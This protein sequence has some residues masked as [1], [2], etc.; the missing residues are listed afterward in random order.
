MDNFSLTD[1]AFC[2]EK[3]PKELQNKEDVLKA[4]GQNGITLEFASEKF[5]ND[6]DVVLNSVKQ[7]GLA[8]KFASKEL[9]N[10]REIVLE[11]IK[12]NSSAMSFVSK[13]LQKDWTVS[14]EFKK[15]CRI[16]LI[17]PTKELQNDKD[18]V[19][20]AMK[21][22]EDAF[23]FASKEIQNN[24]EVVLEA[25]KQDTLNMIYVSK[26]LKN[27]KEIVLE[28][29]KKDG[30]I[31]QFVSK[32]L[33]ND[34]DV[35]LV[36]VNQN[37][38]ALEFASKELQNDK[39]ILLESGMNLQYASKE[40]Q[41]DKEI[42]LKSVKQNGNF[43]QFASKELQNDKEIVLEAMK[44]CG[45]SLKFASKEL[46]ND[47]DIVLEALKKFGNVLEFASKELLKDRDIIIQ[48][49][50]TIFKIEPNLDINSFKSALIKILLEDKT[51]F[52]KNIQ[53]RLVDYIFLE[54]I[55]LYLM[56]FK[57]KSFKISSEL[58]HLIAMKLKENELQENH[59]IEIF[60]KGIELGEN[61]SFYKECFFELGKIFSIGNC[62]NFNLSEEYLNQSISM[63]F[64]VK[65]STSL[66]NK[67][68]KYTKNLDQEEKSILEN[69]SS[70]NSYEIVRYFTKSSDASIYLVK[71]KRDGKE[72]IQKRFLVDSEK[73]TFNTSLKEV[74]MLIKLKH[75]LIC[76]F[77]DFYIEEQEHQEEID[78]YFSIIMP[79]Y[80]QDL[81]N[82]VQKVELEEEMITELILN[83]SYGIHF[84]HSQNI[85]HRD[86]KPEN[87]FLT[88]DFKIK[89]GDFGL[90][91]QTSMQTMRKTQ[92][93]TKS[94]FNV[95]LMFQRLC[96]SRD[97]G[98]KTI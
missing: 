23:Q 42:V 37:G 24:R 25:L 40:L 62:K 60:K 39:E 45:L 96:C 64:K 89:I 1:L 34:K 22:N 66:L 26:E 20:E 75:E 28:C 65:E 46:Q 85:I 2:L 82:Y 59:C 27:D 6:K 74:L 94:N 93:G 4:V 88:D 13:I 31:L 41:N 49:L 86:L 58:L 33:Q 51:K 3:T 11:A 12:Q 71:R 68:Q 76:G 18:F 17:F 69:C 32:E 78:Y 79:M 90:S 50:Q 81:R 43:L 95:S 98:I 35:V 70:A 56:I 55:E 15:K 44:Q 47:K 57:F 48:C 61:F 21:K 97:Y 72:F 9:Q 80:A 10:N 14:S 8:L 38:K 19:L 16:D 63:N 29:V 53:Y 91:C 84:M 83:I 7:N 54:F 73:D 92:C 52:L 67:L 77:E 87:I 36:A 5:Q 30:E